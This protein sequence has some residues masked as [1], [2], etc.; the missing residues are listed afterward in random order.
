MSEVPQFEV[1]PRWDHDK[2]SMMAALI[3]DDPQFTESQEL[4]EDALTAHRQSYHRT[5]FELQNNTIEEIDDDDPLKDL[6]ERRARLLYDVSLI[7]ADID[8]KTRVQEERQ[9]VVDVSDELTAT[10]SELYDTDPTNYAEWE[11]DDFADLVS[12]V[13][14]IKLQVTDCDRGIHHILTRNQTTEEWLKHERKIDDVNINA[15]CREVI[16][17]FTKIYPRK[18]DQELVAE[19]IQDEYDELSRRLYDCPPREATRRLNEITSNWKAIAEQRRKELLEDLTD[20][21][22]RDEE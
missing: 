8:Y 6:E 20:I 14:D 1:K 2:A 9:I 10:A 22:Q 7:D 3:I 16:W 17:A 19:K 5:I 12:E 18:E 21:Y 13:H 11:V 4:V 15:I